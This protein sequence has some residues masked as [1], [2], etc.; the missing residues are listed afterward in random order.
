MFFSG[1]FV[2][3]IFDC[4]VLILLYV[5]L[6]NKWKFFF[7]GRYIVFVCFSISM[8]VLFFSLV[9]GNIVVSLFFSVIV[10]FCDCVIIVYS[11]LILNFFDNFICM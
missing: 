8:F 6:Y 3:C 1:N 2:I 5:S 11:E 10:G 9:F 7:V 4:V